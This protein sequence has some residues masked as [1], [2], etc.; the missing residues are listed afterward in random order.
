MIWRESDGITSLTFGDLERP[1][2]GHLLKN[3]FSVRDSAIVTI[4]HVKE[5]IWRH[6]DGIISLTFG[7]LGRPDQDHLLEKRFSVRDSAI[8]TI[9]HV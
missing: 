7:D 2:Q 3:R 8:V 1:D 6:S 5:M 9:K 4:K